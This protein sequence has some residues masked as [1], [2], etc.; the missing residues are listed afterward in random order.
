[1]NQPRWPGRA[2]AAV[3]TALLLLT[4]LGLALQRR[5]AHDAF[6]W[7][8][9]TQG[10]LYL[11]AVW[12]VLRFGPFRRALLPILMVAVVMRL[13]VVLAPAYLSDDLYR[14]IWDGRVE[15]AGINPY[16]YVPSDTHL[17]ALRDAVIYPNINRRTYAPT[18]YPPAAEYIFFLAS[19]VSESPLAMK[20]A[21]VA[22]ECVSVGVLLHLLALAGQPL[23]RILIYAWHP[24]ALWEFAGSGHID[25]AVV[26]FVALALW[27]RRRDARWLTGIAVAAAALV[28]FFPVVILPALYRRWDWKMPAAATATVAVAY[29]PFLGVGR[30]VLGFLPGYV[31]EEGL[32]NG[33]GFFLWNLASTLLPVVKIGSVAYVAFAAVALL[34]AGLYVLL[35]RETS[36]HVV[37]AALALAT[38]FMVL[39]S[40]HFAWYF[41]WLL[42]FLCLAP[43]AAVLYLSVASI[44]L[45][46]IGGGPDLDGGRMIL[47]LAVYG[48][49][50]V[51]A[52]IEW[53]RYRGLRPPPLWIKREA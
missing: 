5:D 30:A 11:L 51:I 12:L 19:R 31:A 40:P 4:A 37:T 43:S 39:V 46:F 20:A 29:L 21:M 28:K 41:A 25:A 18:I 6:V 9:L 16:R 47:E 15:A 36:A 3:G 27:A 35:R 52:L 14:Y 49:F 13:A 33:A 42:A 17:T 1:V 7:L 38:L 26:T 45:Y 2:L 50:A 53:R 34:A 8:E 44:L 22:L 48:P 24:L 23:E 10:A 32:T